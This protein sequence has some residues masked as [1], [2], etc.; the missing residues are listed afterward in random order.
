[1]GINL[2]VG[3]DRIGVK[4][5]ESEILLGPFWFYMY[6]KNAECA[7]VIPKSSRL[8][9]LGRSLYESDKAQ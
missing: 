9:R 1:M 3:H 7:N 6:L 8:C 4:I 2:I 5:A